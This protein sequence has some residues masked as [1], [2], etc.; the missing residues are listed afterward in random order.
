[1]KFCYLTRKVMSLTAL[2]SFSMVLK[3]AEK[4]IFDSECLDIF[5]LGPKYRNSKSHELF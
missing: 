2:F 5:N 4:Q 3:N 1:M